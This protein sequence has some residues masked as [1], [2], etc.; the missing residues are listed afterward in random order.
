MNHLNHKFSITPPQN[1]ISVAS[2]WLNW[3]MLLLWHQNSW[4]AQGEQKLNWLF[5]TTPPGKDGCGMLS[6]LGVTTGLCSYSNPTQTGMITCV[7]VELINNHSGADLSNWSSKGL[8]L[9]NKQVLKQIILHVT[10]HILQMETRDRCR[11]VHQESVIFIIVDQP[12][13]TWNPL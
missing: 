5:K 13:K 1:N 9:F 2:L 6:N 3:A 7:S 10:Y 4:R 12:V 11:T 8:T